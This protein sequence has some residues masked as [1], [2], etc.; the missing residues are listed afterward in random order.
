MGRDEGRRLGTFRARA[1]EL[2][3]GQYNV[4][5]PP[6]MACRLLLRQPYS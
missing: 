5:Y 2:Y 1:D 6:S 4:T 3:G